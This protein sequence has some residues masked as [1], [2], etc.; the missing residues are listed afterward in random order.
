VIEFA[1]GEAVIWHPELVD[2]ALTLVRVASVALG[3]DASA[4]VTGRAA[5]DALA[6][7]QGPGARGAPRVVIALSPKQVLRK[8]I[9]LPIAVEDNLERTLAYDLDRHTPFRPDQVY[10][11]AVVIDRDPLKKTL[12]VDWAAALKSV[13]DAAKRRAEDWGAAVTAAVPGPAS[14]VP[15]RLNLLP[16]EARARR[17]LW[18]QWQV[19][20]PTAL[21]TLV[22][23]AVIVVPLLQK[24][25]YAI[26]L[27]QQTEAA[28]VQAEAADGVRREFERLQGDYNYA[29]ARKY[30]YPGTVQIIDD[31]T[32]V[33]PDDTWI[34]Q[35]EVKTTIKGKDMQRDVFLR[36]E[37]ANGSKLISVLEDSKLVEQA[38]LRSPTTKLQPGPGEVF[39]LGAQLK[40]I[41][42]PPP[43][44]V[45]VPAA[46]SAAESAAKPPPPA[47]PTTSAASQAPAAPGSA[48]PPS[49]PASV[50]PAPG[51]GSAPATAPPSAPTSTSSAPA[52]TTS[53]PPPSAGAPPA[54]AA[55]PSTPPRAGNRS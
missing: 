16:V 25:G 28:R 5:I 49:T 23:A 20:A 10:F 1:E 52:P 7:A 17:M 8:Q 33:L 27:L 2:G 54:G 37:S 42:A 38:A 3:S 34:S 11:D 29:L 39:D 53:A 48:A 44:M 31:I 12:R 15:S 22:A 43:E 6:A 41:A 36:G 4:D 14:P 13:V 50:T 24:R 47:P 55:T 45:G 9:V 18:T 46:A 51:S 21:V 19:W 30:M 32:R 40:V 26:A 35:L